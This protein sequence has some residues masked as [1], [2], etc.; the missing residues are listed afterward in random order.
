[1]VMSSFIIMLRFISS[2]EIHTIF[3]IHVIKR[4]ISDY[5]IGEATIQMLWVIHLS[6]KAVN[7][8]MW[9][10]PFSNDSFVPFM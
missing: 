10:L 5:Y 6:K 3:A 8:F 2:T 9:A 7:K 1:M 4:V